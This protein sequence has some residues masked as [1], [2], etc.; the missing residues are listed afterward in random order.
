MRLPPPAISSIDE[1]NI[2]IEQIVVT[3]SDAQQI[4]EHEA[5]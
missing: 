5:I 2:Y 4:S 3:D 1:E